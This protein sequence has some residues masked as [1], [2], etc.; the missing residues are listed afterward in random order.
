MVQEAE[1]A[2]EM[3]KQNP[4]QA[5]PDPKVVA[6]QMKQQTALQ[7]GQ[8]DMEKEKLKLQNSLIQGQAEVQNDAQREENQ[9]A[10]NVKEA[11]QRQMISNALK[12]PSPNGRT[13]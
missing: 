8:M 11:A 13:P 2:A 6:E 12:P 9:R 5:P 4:Q 7:K 10:S 1:Q 3:A